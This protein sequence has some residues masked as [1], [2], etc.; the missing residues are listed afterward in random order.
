M[1][2]PAE[3]GTGPS[4]IAVSRTTHDLLPDWARHV[5]YSHTYQLRNAASGSVLHAFGDLERQRGTGGMYL[6]TSHRGQRT[7]AGR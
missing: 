1:P 3:S 7:E 4:D 5:T 6:R 2:I